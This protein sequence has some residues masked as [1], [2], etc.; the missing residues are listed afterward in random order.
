MSRSD[1]GV[2]HLAQLHDPLMERLFAAGALDAHLT[3]VLA[4]SCSEESATTR[5]L[6]AK[7]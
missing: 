1:H 4:R 2:G 6:P 3:P 5:G 7:W